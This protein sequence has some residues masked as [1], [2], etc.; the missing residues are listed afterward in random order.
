[1]NKDKFIV[2][3]ICI[4]SIYLFTFLVAL[5]TSKK[6]KEPTKVENVIETK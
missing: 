5:V 2:A 3:I 4:F 1:M 6:Q